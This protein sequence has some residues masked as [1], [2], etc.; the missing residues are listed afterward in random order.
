[1]ADANVYRYSSVLLFSPRADKPNERTTL[2]NSI[3][4][5]PRQWQDWVARRSRFACC[6]CCLRHRG[7]VGFSV[8]LYA[9]SGA[10]RR[11]KFPG[12]RRAG[13]VASIAVSPSC[14]TRPR[15]FSARSSW[16]RCRSVPKSSAC[17]TFVTV[18]IWARALTK[19]LRLWREAT[20]RRRLPNL[21][22]LMTRSRHDRARLFC[23]RVPGCWRS[24]R[25]SPNTLRI[26][27][28]QRPARWIHNHARSR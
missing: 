2:S 10:S 1:M 16:Q 28:Q 17:G 9:I 25:R 11:A 19:R 7:P 6:R 5:Q 21:P 8:S 27:T 22:I 14:R 12:H 13:S 26:S 20:T 3:M 18:S 23:G 15:R 4:G 24:R